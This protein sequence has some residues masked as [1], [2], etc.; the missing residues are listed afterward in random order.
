M[1]C[2]EIGELLPDL[3]AGL[4]TAEPAVNDHLRSCQDC[5]T[6]LEQ[7]RQTMALLDEWPVPE[8]SPYFDVRLRARLREEQEQPKAGWLVWLRRPSLAVSLAVIL[9]AGVSTFLMQQRHSTSLQPGTAV[10]D[11]QTLDRNHDLFADPDPDSAS[12][13]LDDLQVQQDVNANP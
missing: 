2:T 9:V 5:A 11:L 10:S 4:S 1:K 8:P 6:T 7:F 12:G 13:L 3:A